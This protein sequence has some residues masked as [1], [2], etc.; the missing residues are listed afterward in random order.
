MFK[1]IFDIGSQFS[2]CEPRCITK[3]YSGRV[4]FISQEFLGL[5]HGNQS[6]DIMFNY[7][8]TSRTLVQEYKVYDTEGMIGT[9]GGSLGLFL[10]FSF[11]GVLSDVLD[12]FW[13]KITKQD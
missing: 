2:Q 6:A 4:N 9:L 3:E 7:G 13:K 1:L 5:G 10:G 8:T 12:H 11:Y